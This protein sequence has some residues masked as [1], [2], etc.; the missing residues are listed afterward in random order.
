[1]EEEEKKQI[2]REMMRKCLMKCDRFLIGKWKTTKEPLEQVI[3][4]EVRQS[5][6]NNFY[7]K[8]A[9]E[10]IAS[11][12]TIQKWF[13]IHGQSLP[14]REQIIHLAFACHLSV[15]E[16]RE[17]FMYAISEHD[18]QVNDYR[19]MIALY[20]LEN[21]M[22]YEQYEEMVT[23]FEQYS[24]W[25]VPIRQT[26]HTDEILK[27]YQPV[28]N[29][30]K[31]EFLVWMRKN[32]ALF[33]GYSMTTYQNYMT[34]LEK[35]LTVF[36][37]DVKRCLFTTLEDAGFF[38]WC[39]GNDIKEEDYGK[40]I[41]R[42]IKNQ[43]R[44]VK[45]P[46]SKEEVKE[47]QFLTKMAYSPL[48]RVSDLIV[49]IYDGIHF[50]HTRFGNMKRNLLQKEIG[51]VDAKYISDISSIAKQKERE[52]R[53]L[54]A[55]TKC[56]VNEPKAAD[57]LQQ[58]E[59]EIRKQRQ[60]THNIRRADLLVLIHYVVLKQEGEE[61]PELVKKKFVAT[62]D[63]ILNLCG[64]RPMDDKYPLDYLLL[65]CFGSVDVYTLTDVL[66]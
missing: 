58:I 38:F 8:V 54:Q 23:Y 42:F 59:K 51:A 4:D 6:Y 10:K 33:K 31:K 34:L 43:T 21:H 27:R 50:P 40:E 9:K 55:Y 41:R 14:K 13:G 15:D 7:S 29:L 3:D 36:R 18:F 60:R 62:A 28:K 19:E 37:K 48:P 66:E 56:R 47:I 46:L 32:E 11:R 35:A 26:A 5:A 45:S 63:S 65:Q 25:N 17:Y 44:L 61:L 16:T 52:I 30:D 39:K 24:D 57:K 64:M 1:M 22:T 12:P 49:E 53:L 20:G 2:F